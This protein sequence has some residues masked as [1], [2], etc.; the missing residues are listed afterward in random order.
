[1]KSVDWLPIRYRDFYDIPRMI[2]VAYRDELYLFDSPFDAKADEYSDWFTVYRLPSSIGE[3][4]DEESWEGLP[5]SGEKIGRV[6]TSDVEFDP[7][8]RRS[9]SSAVFDGLGSGG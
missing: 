8:K 1:M 2:I 9:I 4:V 6:A 3:R 5:G 7:S